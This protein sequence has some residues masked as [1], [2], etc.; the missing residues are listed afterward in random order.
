MR[1]PRWSEAGN[2]IVEF[3]IIVPVILIIAFGALDISRAMRVKQIAQTLSRES[4]SLAYRDCSV[5]TGT[6]TTDCLDLV[7][8]RMTNRAGA[9]LPG[10]EIILSLYSY[11][12]VG[13]NITQYGPTGGTSKYTLTRLNSAGDNVGTMIRAQREVVIAEIHA[14][15]TSFFAPSARMFQ[16]GSR[17]FYD[18]SIL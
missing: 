16:L 14:P 13:G 4:A 10:S 9:L 17:I 18:V 5:D 7:Q 6:T 11:D 15:Y 3:A 1:S 8:Q 12:P 2:V